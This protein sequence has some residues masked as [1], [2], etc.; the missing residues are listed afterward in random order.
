MK[1][2]NSTFTNAIMNRV[3]RKVDNVV[4]DMM[5][6]KLGVNTSA[7]IITLDQSEEDNPNV[8]VNMFDQF[9]VSIPAFAQNTAVDKV[10][11]GDLLVGTDAVL[12]WVTEINDKRTK[13]TL[14][15]PSGTIAS[16]TPPKI[17]MLGFDSGVMVVR[18][19]INLLPS[20]EGGLNEMQNLLQTMVMMGGDIDFDKIMPLMLMAQTTQSS[21]SANASS[22]MSMMPMMMLMMANTKGK[23]INAMLPLLMM[24][25]GQSNMMLPLM[26]MNGGLNIGNTQRSTV[27]TT[28]SRWN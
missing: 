7:G 15:K 26:M 5:T 25:G 2:E 27:G 19:L 8:A 12:G 28:D 10:A 14:I 20:G 22:P 11:V 16:W 9:G 4:W 13:F 17:Q 3:F 6:G 1:Q 18:S 23:D 24:S 21:S